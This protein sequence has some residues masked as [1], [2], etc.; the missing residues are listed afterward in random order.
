MKDPYSILGISPSA[1]DDEVKDA[2]RTLARKYHPDNYADDNPLKELANEKMQE[3]N[4]AYDEILRMRA[5]G[6][7]TSQGSSSSSYSG[8][9]SG[10]YYTIRTKIN[11]GKFSEA[12][13]M[14]AEIPI[15]DRNAEWHYLNCVLLM[16]RGYVND[17]MRELEM[18]CN[19]DPSNVEYQRAKQ[20]FNNGAAGYGSTYYGNGRRQSATDDACQC[21]QTLICMD[22]LCECCGGDLIRCC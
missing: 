21:C 12:E 20:M 16:K 2:Y 13:R 4:S 14:I 9:S 3:I 15:S 5:G 11:A 22:C 17:A 18:A 19:M 6:K 7:S 10:V 8:T 1:T